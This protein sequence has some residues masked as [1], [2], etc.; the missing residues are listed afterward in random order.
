MGLSPVTN[1][2][3]SS[4]GHSFKSPKYEI[5]WALKSTDTEVESSVDLDQLDCRLMTRRSKHA[6][7]TIPDFGSGDSPISNI[8]NDV[9]TDKSIKK[10][11][12][13]KKNNNAKRHRS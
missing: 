8:S 11:R 10:K 5:T 2:P 6:V 1:S 3:I 9:K 12:S 4:N 13:K 7:S